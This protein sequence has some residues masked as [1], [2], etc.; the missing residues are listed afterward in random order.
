MTRLV[1]QRLASGCLFGIIVGACSSNGGGGGGLAL[2]DRG[3][4][5]VLIECAATLAPGARDEYEQVYGPGGSCW[6]N[7]P[8]AWA[9]CRDACRSALD[10]LNLVAMAGGETC[11]ACTTDADCSSF[12]LGATCVAGLCT[13]GSGGS[14]DDESGSVD[15]TSIE[16]ETGDT[17]EDSGTDNGECD[18]VAPACQ[19]LIDCLAV[20]LPDVDTSSIGPGSDCWCGTVTEANACIND[21]I[22]QMA[23]AV[24]TY[25]D[26]EACVGPIDPCP[27]G[28]E[29]CECLNGGYCAGTLLCD[30]DWTCYAPD[31]GDCEW[32]DPFCPANGCENGYVFMDQNGDGAADFS[33]CRFYCNEEYGLGECSHSDLGGNIDLTGDPECLYGGNW[34]FDNGGLVCVNACDFDSCPDG[35]L[36]LGNYCWYDLP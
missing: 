35:A 26:I 11:G 21:C 20:A 12:G 36:C 29:G 30:D 1:R 25:P 32:D 31:F 2:L 5:D 3:S 19:E 27:D 13:G 6:L 17:L 16:G 18:P 28:T 15:A 23:T 10:A 34:G 9:A 8:G 24:E 7:G 4:C 33:M 22:E 14:A